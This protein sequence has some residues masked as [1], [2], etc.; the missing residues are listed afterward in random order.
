MP[1][2]SEPNLGKATSH[3]VIHTFIEYRAVEGSHW[4]E[5]TRFTLEQSINGRF[6]FTAVLPGIGP[7]ETHVTDAVTRKWQTECGVLAGV[8]HI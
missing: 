5:P 2:V 8:E 3:G 4:K 6:L 7:L 1:G